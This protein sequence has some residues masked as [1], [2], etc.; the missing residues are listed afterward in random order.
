[1]EYKHPRT[2]HFIN[3]NPSS[4]DK[5][6]QDL[7]ILQNNQIVVTEKMDGENTSLTKCKCYPR[8]IDGKYH[9]SRTYIKSKWVK[10][11]K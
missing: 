3:S 6:Q 5:I 7:S 10:I 4:D 11:K 1:M 9:E 8:S 2:Y